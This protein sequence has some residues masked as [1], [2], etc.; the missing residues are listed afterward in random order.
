MKA[1]DDDDAAMAELLLKYG[2]KTDIQEKVCCFEIF[3]VK[4]KLIVY[5]CRVVTLR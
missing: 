2:A 5:V 1:V 4:Y 3:E